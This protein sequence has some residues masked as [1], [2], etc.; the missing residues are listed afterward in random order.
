[1][2]RYLTQVLYWLYKAAVLLVTSGLSPWPLSPSHHFFSPFHHR[3]SIPYLIPVA[4]WGRSSG[5]G[6]LACI[7]SVFSFLVP[8]SCDLDL[9]LYPFLLGV[10]PCLA[11]INLYL[12]VTREAAVAFH[13]D[14]N[15]V[16]AFLL[17]A[18]RSRLYH[19]TA[20]IA[21]FHHFPPAIIL[22]SASLKRHARNL[23]K[24]CSYCL[25]T[26]TM[27]SSE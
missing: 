4:F 26:E 11:C 15:S 24:Q 14:K 2:R 16:G 23:R 12:L 7:V 9:C 18:P 19:T 25:Y 21:L 22:A 3:F 8:S 27:R 20:S 1:M 17:Q 13:S 6:P 5:L 10:I